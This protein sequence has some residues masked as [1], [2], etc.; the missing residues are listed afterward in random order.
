MQGIALE[1]SPNHPSIS[2]AI[3]YVCMKTPN[4]SIIILLSL[5]CTL[6][7][8]HFVVIKINMTNNMTVL[9]MQVVL[10]KTILS[11]SVQ[12][13]IIVMHMHALSLFF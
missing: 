1:H 8:N 6:S 12:V 7:S 9:A 13:H 11:T 4:I 10:G 5:Q 2:K 3:I